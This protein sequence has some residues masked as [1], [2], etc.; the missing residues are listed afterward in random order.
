MSFLTLNSLSLAETYSGDQTTAEEAS[1][2]SPDE[3]QRSF[4]RL[5]LSL[6]TTNSPASGDIS[7][8][9]PPN[10]PS[11]LN[12]PAVCELSSDM[13]SLRFPGNKNTAKYRFRPY[14]IPSTPCSSVYRSSFE[15]YQPKHRQFTSNSETALEGDVDELRLTFVEQCALTDRS[16]SN[17]Q[18]N[19]SCSV[20]AMRSD[21]SCE[22]HIFTEVD[23]LAEYLNHFVYVRLKLSPQVESLY[24]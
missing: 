14:H 11:K 13:E 20:E 1:G 6:V 22:D 12:S 7:I 5:S 18:M 24:S 21:A 23:L 3:L 15:E 2:S 8:A 16:Q 19:N 10:S 9:A 4:E 17:S